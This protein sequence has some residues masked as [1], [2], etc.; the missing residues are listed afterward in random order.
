MQK[1]LFTESDLDGCLQR[2]FGPRSMWERMNSTAMD[3]YCEQLFQWYRKRG[4]PFQRLTNIARVAEVKRVKAAAIA[5]RNGDDYGFIMHGLGMCWEQMD[6][7]IYVRCNKHRS[8]ADAFHDDSFLRKTIRKCLKRSSSMS[9]NHF[10][11][12]IRNMGSVQKPS[13]FRPVAAAQIYRTIAEYQ[14]NYSMNVWDMCGGYGGRMLGAACSGAVARYTATDPCNATVNGLRK[15]N[16]RIAEV[17]LTGTTL[18]VFESQAENGLAIH[19]PID[20]CFTSPPYF[21]T[22]VYS[23]E[24]TQSCHRFPTYAKWRD[25]FL[26]KM[27]DHCHCLLLRG[28]SL[29]LNVANTKT[30]PTLEAD[31]V[32]IAI[33]QGFRLKAT[34]RYLMGA[35]TKGG[36]SFEPIFWFVKK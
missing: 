11:E 36:M 3:S 4:Y 28:N 27:I 20:A 7:A 18:Q 35:V 9:D 12:T 17:G 34:L 13:N 29:V 19:E 5:T 24:P 15:L 1:E 31:A 21:N 30:A 2:L 25:G 8:V 26:R 32:E 10:R 16:S 6:H 14:G 33:N 23:S 22:E